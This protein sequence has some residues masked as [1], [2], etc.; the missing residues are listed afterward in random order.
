MLKTKDLFFFFFLLP[1]PVTRVALDLNPSLR[2]LQYF[3]CLSIQNQV[4]SCTSITVKST[5][6]PAYTYNNSQNI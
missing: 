5:Y 3:S 6:T 4:A 1:S 2:P